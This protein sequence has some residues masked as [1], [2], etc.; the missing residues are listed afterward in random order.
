MKKILGLT[1]AALLGVVALTGCSCGSKGTYT[2]DHVEYVVDGE[3]KESDCSDPKDENELAACLF[4]SM[5][6][7]KD[8]AITL[9]GNKLTMELDGEV[10]QEFFYKIEDGKI[11][12]SDKEDGEYK[13]FEAKYKFLG[14]LRFEMDINE[15][16]DLIDYT[17]VFKK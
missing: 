3:V 15:D 10:E 11:L 7:L 13:D 12:V 9:K 1:S 4:V 5:G 6:N 17:I 16:D 8:T 14:Q 2:F